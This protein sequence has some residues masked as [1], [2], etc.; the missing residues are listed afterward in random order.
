MNNYRITK[1]QVLAAA[2]IHQHKISGID[3]D[4]NGFTIWLKAEY[5]FAC[6]E[7]GAAGFEFDS[8]DNLLDYV[9]EDCN[10]IILS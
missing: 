3:F 9:K 2:G 8:E 1:S 4:S 5:T 6:N 7:S 10:S